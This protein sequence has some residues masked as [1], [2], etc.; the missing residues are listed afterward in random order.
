MPDQSTLSSRAVMGMYFRALEQAR[1]VGWVD[2][3]AN[4]FTSDQESEQYPFLG[5]VPA[6]REWVGGRQPA[7]LRDDS[8]PLINTHYEATLRFRTRDLRR[9]KTP[10]IQARINELVERGEAHWASLLSTLIINGET[11]LAYDGQAFFDTDHSEG[12]SGTQDNDI[13]VDISAVPANVHGTTTA[14]SKEEMQH[15][16]LKGIEQIQSFKDDR[17][18]PMNEMAQNFLVMV[19]TA[20]SGVT[21]SAVASGNNSQVQENLAASTIDGINVTAVMNARLN[22]DWTDRFPVFRTDSSIRALIRQAEEDVSFKSK[23]EGSEFE[24]DNDMHEYGIDAWR[25]VGYG[26]WQHACLVTLV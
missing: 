6:M 21:K 4:L 16:I 7:E 17:G 9:D 25:T 22:D 12:D 14:P 5:Q 26:Y 20:L 19:P 24:F 11:D 13:T 8:V 1:G 23:A 15:A 18:E 10:Q 3:A 2:A